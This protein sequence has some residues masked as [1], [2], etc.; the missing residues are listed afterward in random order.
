MTES[1]KLTIHEITVDPDESYAATVSQRM[2]QLM[3]DDETRTLAFLWDAEGE[4]WL[5][6]AMWSGEA[7]CNFT[8]DAHTA[9]ML[10]AMFAS[11]YRAA[12]DD[13]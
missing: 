11:L 9:G 6:A 3:A 7:G 12:T 13:T 2:S 4:M 1:M 10:T 5:A 8:V